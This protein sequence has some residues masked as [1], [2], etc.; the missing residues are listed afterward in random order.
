ELDATRRCFGVAIL[1]ELGHV[2]GMLRHSPRNTD[3]M[4][5]SPEVDQL[6]ARDRNT[7][8]VMYHAPSN[9]VLLPAGSF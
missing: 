2:I 3:L 7:A 8:E 4:F 5:A 1:H 9:V 6:S